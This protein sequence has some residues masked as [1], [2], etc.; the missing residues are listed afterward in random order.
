MARAYSEEFSLDL[1]ADPIQWHGRFFSG[2]CNVIFCT[3]AAN[4]GATF[5]LMA[6]ARKQH[7][8]AWSLQ[9]DFWLTGTEFRP[10]GFLAVNLPNIVRERETHASLR[11]S[12]TLRTSCCVWKTS[13]GTTSTAFPA[14]GP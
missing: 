3:Q 11:S 13:S 2:I 9:R 4:Y 14:A 8:N 1:K 7:P 10:P 5:D 6:A 12:R